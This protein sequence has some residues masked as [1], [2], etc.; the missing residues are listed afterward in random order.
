V[1]GITQPNES[2]VLEEDEMTMYIAVCGRDR[3][4]YIFGINLGP[5]IGEEG[6]RRNGMNTVSDLSWLR[7]SVS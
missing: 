4:I 3:N 7:L 2:R 6:K 5:S 1:E